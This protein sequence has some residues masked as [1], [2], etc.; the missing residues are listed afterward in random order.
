MS[1]WKQT[2]FNI[3]TPELSIPI[4]ALDIVIFTIYQWEL[5]IILSQATEKNTFVIPGWIVTK[6][7]SLDQNFDDILKRK[8]GMSWVYKEQLY[9]FWNPKRDPRG[10]VV[11]VCYYAL[12][13]I[14][15]FVEKIDFTKVNIVKWNDIDTLTLLYDHHEILKYAKQRLE[16]KLEYTN[17]VQEILPKKFKMSQL[18]NIYEK[19]TGKIF[20]KRNFQKKIFS[21]WI[22]TETWD[23]DTSSNRPAKLYE[24]K[25]KGLKIIE[26]NSFV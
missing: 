2:P 19:I 14:D 21:L 11:S 15:A 10:H 24:F 23:F 18:Q 1:L 8:T 12:V 22:L 9:T 6:W 7:L 3:W 20:D 16:W 25:D 26:N 5:C 4:L 17:V 13:N